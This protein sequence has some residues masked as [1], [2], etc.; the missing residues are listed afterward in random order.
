MTEDPICEADVLRALRRSQLSFFTERVFAELEPGRPY[1]HNW[2]L[3]HVAWQLMRV[4]R[5]EIRRLIITMPP[6]S[7][8]SI[9]ASI[10]FPALVLGHDPGK[11]II[12][13]SYADS[14]ARKLSTDSRIVLQSPWYRELFPGVAL[15]GAR[16][17]ELITAQHGYRLASGGAGSLLGRGADLIV[18]DDPIKASDVYSAA[19]RRRVCEFYDNTLYTRLNDKST[20][21]IVIV[22][23]RLHEDDL[24]GHVLAKDEWEV[25]T[26]PAIATESRTYRLSDSPGDVYHRPAGA[27]LHA[28]RE[29][30]AALESIRRMQ[31]SLLFATQYQQEPLP[32]AGNIVKRDWLRRYGTAPASF[33]TIVASWD[34]ASTLGE[35]SDYSVGTVWGSRGLDFYLL[36]VVR[37]RLEVPD[38]RRRILALSQRWRV[39]ATLVEDTELGRA[40]AQDLRRAGQASCLLR[41][42]RFDKLARM[43][44][45]SAR[46][47][48]G[49]VY[50]PQDAPWLAGWMSELLAFPTGRHD[51]Q[52]DST[53]QA[54]DYLSQHSFARQ[55]DRT[56]RVRPAGPAAPAGHPAPARARTGAARSPAVSSKTIA[57]PSQARVTGV[58]LSRGDPG[59]T[60]H[61]SIG[62]L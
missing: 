8:K 20:G 58:A 4:A 29:P 32:E 24:V 40:I 25:V 55:Q 28:A 50:V 31:G 15:T 42:P 37:E 53:S 46:F 22:M 23:Q 7:M 38:L 11:R 35:S 51:D 34:T 41:R 52:V 12:C 61:H 27:V 36:E 49:Q 59:G 30:R 6:R 44:A 33:D 16:T 2:H 3:D 47:E 43:L 57:S 62:P 26:L 21:A 48:A 18:I 60:R 5:G 1:L 19:E 10:A 14:F 9:S 54:L 39:D 13:V 45:Q 56:P 17:H